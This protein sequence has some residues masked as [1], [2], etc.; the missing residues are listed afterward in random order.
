[1]NQVMDA[2]RPFTL[3]LANAGSAM[4]IQVYLRSSAA[5]CFF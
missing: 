3:L 2:P 5:D 4:N 1:M